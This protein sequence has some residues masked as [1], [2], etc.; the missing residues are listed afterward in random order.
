MLAGRVLRATALRSRNKLDAAARALHRG[1]LPPPIAE[2]HRLAV[3]RTLGVA[4]AHTAR[5]PIFSKRKMSTLL[6]GPVT[7]GREWEFVKQ[8]TG[9]LCTFC[10]R[11]VYVRTQQTYGVQE[12][13]GT[14]IGARM[15][16]PHMHSSQIYR[17]GHLTIASHL[18]LFFRRVDIC[19]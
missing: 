13:V 7:S 19:G 6:T 1:A 3:C 2:G 12:V 17:C 14:A 9:V 11:V 16:L 5:P 8:W 4:L 15:L 10:Q 18:M